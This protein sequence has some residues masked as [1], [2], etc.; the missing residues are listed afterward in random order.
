MAEKG[1]ACRKHMVSIHTGEQLEPWYMRIQHKGTVPALVHGD[2]VKT[3]SQDVIM[4]LD[5]MT[6]HGE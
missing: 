1:I 2:V 4:Y 5:K 3:D 6:P